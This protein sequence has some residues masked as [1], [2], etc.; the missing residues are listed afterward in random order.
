MNYIFR[1]RTFLSAWFNYLETIFGSSFVWL[2]F[3][4]QEKGGREHCNKAIMVITDGPSETYK[5]IFEKHNW[6][7]KTVSCELILCS[8]WLCSVCLSVYEERE[9]NRERETER[10]RITHTIRR[11]RSDFLRDLL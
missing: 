9:R 8:C 1:V 4:P 11:Q 10:E 3:F 2:R 6:P 5:E 7:N